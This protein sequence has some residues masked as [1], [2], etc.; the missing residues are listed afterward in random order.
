VAEH[1]P[2]P[3][4]LTS[5][6]EGRSLRLPELGR[7]PGRG[8]PLPRAI[9]L[10]AAG[11]FAVMGGA[12]FALLPRISVPT[13]ISVQGLIEPSFSWTV[14]SPEAGVISDILVSVGESVIHG[15][16]LFGLDTAGTNGSGLS[17]ALVRAPGSGVVKAADPGGMARMTGRRIEPGEPVLELID[18]SE[19][20]VRFHV[21]PS[22]VSQI[23]LGDTVLV[24]I[25]AVKR[26][27][28]GPLRAEIVGVGTSPSPNAGSNGLFAVL[29]RIQLPSDPEVSRSLR[30]GF[31]ARVELCTT[32][33]SLADI[34]R[35]WARRKSG[36]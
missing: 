14:Q 35:E 3:P 33:K 29:G 22:T 34:I 28:V 20:Q 8:L 27:A 1:R 15:Q 17:T 10:L 36:Q 9:V 2:L 25:D 21:G 12:A 24:S 11:L 32:R 18:P 26:V 13:G 23:H 16:P 31:P 30:D 6:R 4:K 7:D 5:R 19:W